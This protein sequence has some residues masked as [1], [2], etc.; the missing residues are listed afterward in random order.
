MGE[1]SRVPALSRRVPGGAAKWPTPI[2]SATPPK[3][4]EVLAALAERVRAATGAEDAITAPIPVITA[5]LVSDLASPAVEEIRLQPEGAAL[6]GRDT[7]PVGAGEAPADREPVAAARAQA[8]QQAQR[9]VSGRQAPAGRRKHAAAALVVA[10]VLIAVG[11]VAFALAGHAAAPAAHRGHGASANAHGADAAT[12]NL[13]AAWVAGQVSR[14]AIVSCDQAMC[15]ALVVHGT[16]LDDLLQ[17][18]QEGA[19]PLRSEVIVATA[20]VRRQLGS[21]LSSVY[22]PAVIA[23]F[24]SGSRRIDIRQVAP[25]G[26]AAYAAAASADLLARR[27]SGA[28]LLRSQ[29][30]LVSAATRRQLSAGQVDSRLLITIA[31]LAALHPVRIVAFGDPSPGAGQGSPLRSADLADADATA[32]RRGSSAYVKSMLAFLRAQRA[33]YLPARAGA[34]RI[35]DGQSILRIE[36]AAPSPLGLLDPLAP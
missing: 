14:S 36:F 8:E 30:I 21:R 16:S 9:Q 17:L 1:D 3:L 35:A 7:Q 19:D 6:P 18:A 10:L 27:A 26:A 12:R 25:H 31:G 24:G 22:A 4:P 2:A 29:R 23:S 20:D 5:P 11:S 15:S 28:E 34:V 13:A 33:P 32:D